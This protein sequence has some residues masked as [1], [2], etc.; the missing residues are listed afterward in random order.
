MSKILI[1]DSEFGLLYVHLSP[2][3]IKILPLEFR[4]QLITLKSGSLEYLWYK[5]CIYNQW[6][7]SSHNK[8]VFQDFKI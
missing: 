7:N 6:H 3:V 5:N 2:L 4:C 8:Y 1:I